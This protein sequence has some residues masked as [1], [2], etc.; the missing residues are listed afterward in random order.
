LLGKSKKFNI[1]RYFAILDFFVNIVAI[2]TFEQKSHGHSLD[3]LATINSLAEEGLLKK[4]IT[5]KSDSTLDDLSAIA[6]KCN[7][8]SNFIN[9]VAKKINF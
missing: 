4:S 8:D 1:D 3:F 9:E 5:K 7:F 2:D 6:F